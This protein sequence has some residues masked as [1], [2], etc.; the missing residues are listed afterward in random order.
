MVGTD[1]SVQYDQAWAD[2]NKSLIAGYAEKN[3]MPMGVPGPGVAASLVTGGNMPSGPLTRP[4]RGFTNEDRAA[5]LD[6]LDRQG[7]DYEARSLREK[8]KTAS[9]YG[10]AKRSDALLAQADQAGIAAPPRVAQLT[11]PNPNEAARLGME[12]QKLAMDQNAARQDAEQQGL[13]TQQEQIKLQNAQQMQALT[14]S[15]LS[16]DEATRKKAAA[17]MATLRGKEPGQPFTSKIQIPVGA[18]GQTME[19]ERRFDGNGNRLDPPSQIE[20]LYEES[21]RAAAYMG[22]DEELV[23]KVW[24]RY[25]KSVGQAQGQ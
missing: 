9:F 23:A 1:G 21:L 11:R 14:D 13:Q 3:V 18:M 2:K 24:D 20:Q 8:A 15:L 12:Q 5:Q 22:D 16:G 17:D 4:P 25:N 7:R 10:D 6:N 19:F